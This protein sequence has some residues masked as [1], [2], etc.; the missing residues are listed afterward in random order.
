MA[1]DTV[2]L[3]G[4]ALQNGVLVHGPT[5]WGCAVRGDDG[6]AAHRGGPEAA[7]RSG[8]AQ[9]HAGPAWPDRPRRGVR[10]P[11]DG[12]ARDSAGALPVRAAER[13]RRD[14][15][16]R[17]RGA[18]SSPLATLGRRRGRSPPPA[19]RSSRRRFALRG[20]DLAAYHG[21]EHISIGTYE[22][23][24]EPRAEGAS[25]LRIAA[26][27]ADGRVVARRQRGR[28]EG[29]GGHAQPRAPRRDGRRDRR[30]RRGLLVGRP[31]PVAPPRAGARASGLRAPAPPLD[32]RAVR[33]SAR[34]RERCPRRLPRA[35]A[36]A[37]RSQQLL[38]FKRLAR[39]PIRV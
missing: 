19:S 3:G 35:R 2:R 33:R 1:E 13:A 22:N 29:A 20:P 10:A 39:L 27:R 8:G 36:S 4:M 24:G 7:P 23:G 6:D 17:G 37:A 16:H 26:H 18:G 28:R 31:Q 25:A 15:R 21:A 5:S 11:A 12:A 34:G 30:L 14:P 32:G 38:R 9:A